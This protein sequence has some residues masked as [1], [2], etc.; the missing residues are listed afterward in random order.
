MKNKIV[1]EE[2]ESELNSYIYEEGY[3]DAMTNCIEKLGLFPDMTESILQLEEMLESRIKEIA[4]ILK[5]L[6]KEYEDIIYTFGKND[7]IIQLK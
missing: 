2:K 6:D 3:K 7:F 1:T 4:P 5:W